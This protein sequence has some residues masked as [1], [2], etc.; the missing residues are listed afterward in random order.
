MRSVSRC[1]S[2]ADVTLDT[3]LIALRIPP[4]AP[5]WLGFDLAEVLAAVGAH[6][7][8][9]WVVRDA[10]FNG[11]VTA[12]WPEGLG[13]EE[14]T[15]TDEGV[16]LSW[17]EMATLARTCHQVIDGEFSGYRGAELRL[18]LTAFDSSYWVVLA[19]DP[20]ILSRVRGAFTGV[21]ADIP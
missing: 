20:A 8:L 7:N 17:S 9:R 21:C 6:T 2:I 11:D 18:R 15:R 5:R 3:G 1:V 10:W 4:Q 19:E 13:V 12:V 16:A 14:R